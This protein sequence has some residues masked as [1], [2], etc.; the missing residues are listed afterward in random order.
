MI[1]AVFQEEIQ[2]LMNIDNVNILSPAIQVKNQA[3]IKPN[4]KFNMA[5]AVVIGFFIGVGLTFLLE[6]LDTTIK[7]EQDIEE[8]LDLPILGFI[9][10][11]TYKKYKNKRQKESFTKKGKRRLMDV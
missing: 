3:P 2:V 11:I 8:L 10:P 4:P 1:A 7:T 5:L 6:F 9:S